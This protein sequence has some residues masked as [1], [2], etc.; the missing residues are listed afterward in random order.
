MYYILYIIYYIFIYYIIIYYIVAGGTTGRLVVS[1]V[2]DDF[3]FVFVCFYASR[4]PCFII[5]QATCHAT[6]TG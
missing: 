4:A 5:V 6:L 2:F 3:L 1:C